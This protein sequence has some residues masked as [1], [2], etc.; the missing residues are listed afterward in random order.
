MDYRRLDRSVVYQELKIYKLST[1]MAKAGCDAVGTGISTTDNNH[2]LPFRRN[3]L[4]IRK[5]RIEE[6]LGILP[7]ELHGEVDSFNWR[8]GIGKSRGLVAPVAN[9]IASSL[10]EAF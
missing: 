10:T 9:R 8:P 5:L 3:E 6:A 2:F 7:Q 4:L 1:T